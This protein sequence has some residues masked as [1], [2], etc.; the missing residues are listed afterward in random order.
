MKYMKEAGEVR[1]GDKKADDM[2]G[3]NP[4]FPNSISC[5]S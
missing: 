4:D 2:S 5:I 3:T 1:R